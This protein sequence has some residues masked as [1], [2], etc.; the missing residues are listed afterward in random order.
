[1]RTAIAGVCLWYFECRMGGADCAFS[2]EN[3]DHEI[4]NLVTKA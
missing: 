2:E 3:G 1:M 4:E